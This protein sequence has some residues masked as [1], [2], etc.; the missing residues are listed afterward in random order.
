MTARK[1]KAAARSG[2]LMAPYVGGANPGL[3]ALL[4]IRYRGVY[5]IRVVGRETS[6]SYSTQYGVVQRF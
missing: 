6:H 5:V 1:T 3:L 4:P 2:I